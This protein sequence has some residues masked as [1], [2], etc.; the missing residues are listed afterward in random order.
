VTEGNQ[1]EFNPSQL[2]INAKLARQKR[3]GNEEARAD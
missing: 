1:K 3:E 2:R